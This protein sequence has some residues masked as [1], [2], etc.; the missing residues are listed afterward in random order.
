M[1]LLASVPGMI[2]TLQTGN[3]APEGLSDLPKVTQ[4]DRNP[5][6]PS[7][8]PWVVHPPLCFPQ[9]SSPKLSVRPPVLKHLAWP[10]EAAAFSGHVMFEL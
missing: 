5:G 7:P 6:L 2:F 9:S 8:Q 4:Q 1:E 3:G 10:F